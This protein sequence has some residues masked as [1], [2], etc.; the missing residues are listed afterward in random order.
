[1]SDAFH[2]IG[3]NGGTGTY[4]NDPMTES[5]PLAIMSEG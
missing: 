5:K 1:M 4:G 3:Y 2:Q